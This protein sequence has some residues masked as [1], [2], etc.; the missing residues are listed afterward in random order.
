MNNFK[1][2][3]TKKKRE[4]YTYNL[5]SPGSTSCKNYILKNGDEHMQNDK[6][7]YWFKEKLKL[8]DAN[9]T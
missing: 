9:L 5:P 7:W 3:S 6:L 2:K 8:T 4:I 1:I